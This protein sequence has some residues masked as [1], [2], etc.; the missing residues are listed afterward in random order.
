[1]SNGFTWDVKLNWSLYRSIIKELGGG[2]SQIQIDGFIDPG[3]YAIVGKPFNVIQGSRIE[4]LNGQRV[5]DANGDWLFS[6]DIGIIG[7]PNPDWVSALI[8]NFSYKGFVLSAQLEYRYGGDIYSATARTM[9]ARGITKDTDF[10]RDQSM[11][12]PGVL[13]DG[14]PNNIQTSISTGFF[15]NIGFGPSEV[16]IFDGT[17]IR[18]REVSLGYS[19]PKSLLSKTPIKGASI[20]FLGQNLWYRAVNFPKYVNFDTDVL[21]TGV[22][23]GLGLELI[24]GPSSRR[25]GVSLRINL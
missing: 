22:S 3:N 9:L 23:N 18:L 7:N 4:R 11:I 5:V 2:L 25:Y 17:T 15:N 19:L 16:S 6:D 13:Q 10:D 1:M 20:T 8:N 24:T 21:S 12:L 14:T